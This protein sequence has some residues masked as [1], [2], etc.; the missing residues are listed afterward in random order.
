MTTSLPNDRGQLFLAILDW[1][2]AEQLSG[3]QPNTPDVAKRFGLSIEECDSIY[4]ELQN[5]GEF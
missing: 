3:R 1:V 2:L 4:L 5:M